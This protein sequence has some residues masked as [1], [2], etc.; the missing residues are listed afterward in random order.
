MARI[1]VCGGRH[2]LLDCVTHTHCNQ[3][4]SKPA[5]SV[6]AQSRTQRSRTNPE[7]VLPRSPTSGAL[8]H[9]PPNGRTQTCGKTPSITDR[10]QTLSRSCRLDPRPPSRHQ[11]LLHALLCEDG[12]STTHSRPSA[13]R[14]Y[15]A[16]L[17]TLCAICPSWPQATVQRR[18]GS[19]GSCLGTNSK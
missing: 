4:L 5:Y 13:P 19:Y 15:H 6:S 12:T 18:S 3:A 2:D 1:H 8:Q 14:H 9:E 11:S 10:S 16:V 7:S 17:K